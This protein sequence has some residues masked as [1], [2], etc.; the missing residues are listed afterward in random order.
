MWLRYAWLD[1]VEC[2]LYN[3]QSNLPMGPFLLQAANKTVATRQSMIKLNSPPRWRYREMGA[4]RNRPPLWVSTAGTFI[5]ATSTRT[6]SRQL[7]T[8]WQQMECKRLS[9]LSFPLF[10]RFVFILFLTP[11]GATPCRS[12]SKESCR[13]RIRQH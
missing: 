1:Y 11:R 10:F 12:F 13:L 9:A 3:K 5:T 2:V 7:Q 8:R 6:Q 4:S